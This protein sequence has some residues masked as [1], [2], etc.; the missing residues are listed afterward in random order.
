MAKEIDQQITSGWRRFGQY[1]TFLRDKKMPMCL[2]KKIMNTVILPAMTYGVETWSLTKHQKNKLVVAQRSTKRAMLNITRRDRIR[3]EII[4]SKTKINDIIEKVSK[5]KGQW[6]GH[7]AR[8]RN[9]K[10]AK[11]ST[12][13]TPRE[14]RRQRGRR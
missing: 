5:M 8:M 4:R 7:I 6:A 2:K 10:W 13:W 3:N 14:G 1:N 9:N 12:E 11:N